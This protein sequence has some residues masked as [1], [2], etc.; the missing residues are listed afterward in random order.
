MLAATPGWDDLK[1]ELGSA[2][3]ITHE[4]DGTVRGSLDDHTP[5]KRH[6]RR[7]IQMTSEYRAL[8]IEQGAINSCDPAV[9]ERA[10]M[11][12]EVGMKRRGERPRIRWG[13]PSSRTIF[14]A[15]GRVTRISR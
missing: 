12:E 6:M 7:F 10:A 5:D 8:D 13:R 1:R 11:S 3:T 9:V 14:H 15:D 4:T 2:L